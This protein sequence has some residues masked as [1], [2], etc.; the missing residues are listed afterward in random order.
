MDFIRQE[1]D[2]PLRRCG[3]E[4]NELTPELLNDVSFYRSTIMVD[5]I[6]WVIIDR[7]GKN[8]GAIG[9]IGDKAAVVAAFYDDYDANKNGSVSAAEWII[10]KIS[11]LSVKGMNVVEVAMQARFEEKVF[12]RDDTFNTMAMNLFTNFAR[13]LVADG[14]YAAYF[15]RGVSTVAG[16]IA[17]RIASNVVAQ[18]AI[19]RGMEAAVKAAYDAA[20]K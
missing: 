10:G 12:L 7:F 17:G 18:F 13:N 3:P 1:Y 14:I 9:F 8:I 15:S 5:N 6:D 4:I 20:M 16:P 19:R 2:S 11:P